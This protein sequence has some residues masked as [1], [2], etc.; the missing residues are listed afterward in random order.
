MWTCRRWILAL[1]SAGGP[2]RRRRIRGAGT[3]S[4][5]LWTGRPR[6]PTLMV[7]PIYAR[8]GSLPCLVGRRA[9]AS[10]PCA[11]PGSTPA[12]SMISGGSVPN[13]RCSCGRTCLTFRWANIGNPPPI[14]RTCST[15][16]PAVLQYS[17][18]SA[19]VR[20]ILV[21]ERQEEEL[22][23]R[24][25]AIHPAAT[26]CR[27]EQVAGGVGDQASKRSRAIGAI[28]ERAEAD[29]G[30]GSAGVAAGGLG[31]LEHRAAAIHPASLCR[32]EQ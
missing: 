5:P 25:A 22:E 27:A 18:A 29:E 13:C 28:G 4:S 26:E 7:I 1:W 21:K 31:D 15:C 30:G 9:R 8:T 16:C 19:E 11:L 12:A 2:A 6:I 24:A 32:A 14:G 20:D 17:M 23:H 3:C 10:K